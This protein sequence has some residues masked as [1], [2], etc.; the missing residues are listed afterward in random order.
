M[1]HVSRHGK[2]APFLLLIGM[3]AAC[4]VGT[5]ATFTLSSASVDATYTCPVGAA[6]APYDMKAVIDV[7]NSTS[8]AVTIKS[9]AAAMTLMAVKGSWLE[10][11]GDKYQASDIGFSPETVAPGSSASLKVILPSACTNGKAAI[12]GASYGDYSIA[13][14]V[15]TSAGTQTIVSQNRHRIVAA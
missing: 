14:T 12:A 7:R 11:V 2:V 3:A 13:F 8:S 10:K 9:V 15:V 6:D 5:P 1:G 4:T